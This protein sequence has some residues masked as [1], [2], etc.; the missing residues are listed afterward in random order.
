MHDFEPCRMFTPPSGLVGR[1][2]LT[3]KLTPDTPSSFKIKSAIPRIVSR[4]RRT[5]IFALIAA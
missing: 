4:F 3:D 2:L 5:H 1:V